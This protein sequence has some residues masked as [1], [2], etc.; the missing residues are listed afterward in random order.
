VTLATEGILEME[1]LDFDFL[2]LKNKTKLAKS[3]GLEPKVS[4]RD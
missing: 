3:T 1:S 2:F 4:E